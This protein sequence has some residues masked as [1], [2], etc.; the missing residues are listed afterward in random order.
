M[1]LELRGSSKHDDVAQPNDHL[2][3][4][5]AVLVRNPSLCSVVLNHPFFEARRRY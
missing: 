5:G 1:Q 2:V 3:P 4:T